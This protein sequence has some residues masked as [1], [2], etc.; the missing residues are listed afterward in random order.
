MTD[1]QHDF[2]KFM[3][4]D[5]AAPGDGQP[6][7]ILKCQ[8]CGYSLQPK[9]KPEP[10]LSTSSQS[11]RHDFII[12]CIDDAGIVMTHLYRGRT[13][14]DDSGQTIVE[15]DQ[16]YSDSGERIRAVQEM[17]R[18]LICT[19]CEREIETVGR[20]C[21]DCERMLSKNCIRCGNPATDSEMLCYPC[22][23]GVN[24]KMDT[25]SLVAEDQYR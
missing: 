15:L 21:A 10:K 18:D 13:L 17:L 20:L 14:R 24:L 3:V 8:L 9:K 7:K 2:K 11:N 16:S 5:P 22:L 25:W 23:K 6:V 19:S 4:F 1:C 12:T